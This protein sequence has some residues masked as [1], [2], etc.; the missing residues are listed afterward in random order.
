[1]ELPLIEESLIFTQ[2]NLKKSLDFLK[3]ALTWPKL[4]DMLTFDCF[5]VLTE[6]SSEIQFDWS[7]A[8]AVPRAEFLAQLNYEM[9]TLYFYTE[10]YEAATD[11]FVQAKTHL[12][13][14]SQKIGFLTVNPA[15][16]DS[17]LIAC[18]SQTSAWKNTLLHQLHASVSSHFK[19]LLNILLQDN[20]KKQIP[21][22]HRVN[23]ELDIAAAISS[24]KFTVARDLL[25]KV[26]ALNSLRYILG[27]DK[28]K[29]TENEF[30]SDAFLWGLSS[31]WDS[32]AQNEKESIVSFVNGME[33]GQ[34]GDLIERMKSYENLA[35]LGQ[36]VSL[37]ESCG[38]D[39]EVPSCLETDGWE[40]YDCSRKRNAVL[41]IRILEQQ[42][43]ASYD[44]KELRELLNR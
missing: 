16:L 9:A 43:V 31:T 10:E 34:F 32:L 3:Q 23:I 11:H 33:A 12:D 40:P 37:N 35:Q 19:G 24:G 14:V 2:E 36:D 30:N 25:P 13:S 39:L 7:R 1:M 18:N 17:Y 26:Q 38:S 8:V 21:L 22:V 28:V 4:P 5:L 6:S 44:P 42:I 20:L 41:E 15:T 27:N 29:L